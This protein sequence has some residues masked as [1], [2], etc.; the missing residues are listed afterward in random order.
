[1]TTTLPE[2]AEHTA[3]SDTPA[4]LEIQNLT[5]SYRGSAQ[6]AV[7]GVNLTVGP[8]EVVAVIGESGSGKSTLSRAAIGLLPAAA[9]IESGSIRVDGREAT[10]LGNGMWSSFAEK[11]SPWSR[12]IRRP[13]W[14]PYSRSAVS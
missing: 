10:G 7:S 14:I 6:P 11:P 12:R 9:R 2:T 5:I 4:V 1:M 13:R 8:G 3:H